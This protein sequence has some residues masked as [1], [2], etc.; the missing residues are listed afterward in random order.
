MW[1]LGDTLNPP[2]WKHPGRPEP[3]SATAA[4][5]REGEAAVVTQRDL[6]SAARAF[7]KATP[8]IGFGQQ[9][10]A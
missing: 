6:E 4:V 9:A 8:R 3:G 1:P 7:V 2:R 10:L 5:R